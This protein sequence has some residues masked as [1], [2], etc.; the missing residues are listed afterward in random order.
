MV[1]FKSEQGGRGREGD[2]WREGGRERENTN[3]FIVLSSSPV[4][5]NPSQ[6]RLDLIHFN[7]ILKTFIQFYSA[8]LMCQDLRVPR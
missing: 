7:P 4:Y 1:S 2:G 6:S 8:S 5:F 3:S